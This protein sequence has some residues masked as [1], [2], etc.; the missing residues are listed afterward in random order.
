MQLASEWV[1]TQ[2]S[3]PRRHLDGPSRRRSRIL[4]CT[5]NP[6]V[7]PHCGRRQR[8]T[9]DDPV[10]LTFDSTGKARP[11]RAARAVPEIVDVEE[12]DSNR[13]STRLFEIPE[14]FKHRYNIAHFFANPSHNF[15]HLDTLLIRLPYL[16]RK[17]VKRASRK[18]NVLL[19]ILGDMPV[20]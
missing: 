12:S 16:C 17:L 13:V 9:Q 3:P 5:F 14:F 20:I 1:V 18:Y 11:V 19:V 6:T 4:T 7:H 10:S 2:L 8:I 15:L